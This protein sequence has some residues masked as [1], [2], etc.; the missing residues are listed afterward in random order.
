MAMTQSNVSGG[1]RSG[2]DGGRNTIDVGGSG[3][4][5]QRSRQYGCIDKQ[6]QQQG[7]VEGVGT[8]I[9]S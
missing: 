5:A 1:S 2:I 6:V 7:L 4:A 8:A 3:C 9:N